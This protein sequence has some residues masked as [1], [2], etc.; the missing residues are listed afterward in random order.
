MAYHEPRPDDNIL[1]LVLC[2]R[3][4]EAKNSVRVGLL[5]VGRC[6]VVVV[7]TTLLV[8]FVVVAVTPHECP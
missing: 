3:H 8:G 2:F 4:L 6:A 1:F 5:R 7:I